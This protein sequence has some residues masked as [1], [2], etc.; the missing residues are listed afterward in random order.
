MNQHILVLILPFVVVA[1]YIYYLLLK[2]S[3]NYMITLNTSLDD[4]FTVSVTGTLT[5]NNWLN[6]KEYT[7]QIAWHKKTKESV[8]RQWLIMFNG[9]FPWY[10]QSWYDL[11]SLSINPIN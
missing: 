11:Q 10:L 3:I 4:N 6:P 5:D 9:E 8:L 1:Y 7:Y 2:H